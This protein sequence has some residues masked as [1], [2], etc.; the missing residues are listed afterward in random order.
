MSTFVIALRTALV[1][2]V[3]TGLLYPLAIT[4]GAQVLFPHRANGSIIVDE[5][6]REVGSEL[7][8]Q[9][10]A[11]PTYFHPRPSANAY[12]AANSGG[13]N[14]GP[15]SKKLRDSVADVASAYRKDNKLSTET[16]LPED[17]VTS[18]ASGLDPDISPDNAALQVA[19]VATARGI[20]PERVTTILAQYTDGRD[21]GFLGEPRVNVLA[22]NLALDR[23]FG[24]SSGESS[25]ATLA[26]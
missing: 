12:D 9:S 14:F 6:G 15:T 18:S 22:I 1:T 24:R 13:T 5:R 25:K 20:A 7:L 21:L 16:E 10:F 17:A 11:D 19:R 8:G 26:K 23:S 2:L 4:A 3:L